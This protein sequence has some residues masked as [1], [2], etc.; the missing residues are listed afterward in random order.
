MEKTA[1]RITN[2][3]IVLFIMAAIMA[4]CSTGAYAV[5]A[6]SAVG[7]VNSSDGVVLRKSTST[8]SKKVAVLP[9]NTIVKIQKE[10]F[11]KKKS[12]SASNKWYYVSVNGKKGYI[13]ADLIDN[14]N[15][16]VVNGNIKY[17]LS[18]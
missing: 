6:P 2:I 15:Y 14:I 3:C 7:Q 11:K 18:I 4:V 16:G 8:S 10:I 12:T 17:A 1:N 13:R 9:D 5:S